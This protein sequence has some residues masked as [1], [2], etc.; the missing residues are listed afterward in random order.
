MASIS[1]A[2]ALLLSHA[3]VLGA[4]INNNSS[5][6]LLTRIPKVGIQGDSLNVT[7]VQTLATSS[8]LTSGA[9]VDVTATD[10][11]ATARSFP[12][13]RVSVQVQ[14]NGDIAQNVS[15]INDIFE[16]Q[17]QAKM[18]SMWNTVG[19]KL[20][21]GTG[22][23]PEPYG[24]ETLAGQNPITP[25]SPLAGA[26]T[27]LTLTD[28]DRLIENLYPWDGGA[29][30][31]FVMNRGQYK[32]LFSLAR[33]SGF[34]LPIYPD[35]I[36][37]RPVV[38]YAGVCVLVSDFIINT[39]PAANTTSVYLVYLGTRESEPQFGGLVWFYN[40]DTGPGI[41]VDGPH[42][43][44]GTADLLYTDLELNIGFASLSKGA[45]LRLKEVQP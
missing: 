22:T 3:Q 9:A 35:P 42:R 37:G 32:K 25:L 7:P 12:L 34:D 13:R 8:F 20:I 45:V 41:R 33:A 27:P 23:D 39:E 21:Y 14:V 30:R 5:D 43:N 19:T 29:P 15:A 18:V 31:A 24:I 11:E 1:R 36:L 17:I 6:Q 10:Y 2:Q 28:M 16:Q 4:K 38:H 26:N 40:Q 44:S